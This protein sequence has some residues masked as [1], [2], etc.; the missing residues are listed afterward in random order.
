[1]T[2]LVATPADADRLRALALAWRGT[3]WVAEGALRGTGASCTGLPYGILAE[4]GHQA[5]VPPSRLG[6]RKKDILE[7]CRTWLAAHPDR[8]APVSLAQIQ[9]GDVLLF[10]CG[11]G[12]MAI[13]LGGTEVLHSWQTT[14]AH[15]ANFAEHRLASRLVGAWRPLA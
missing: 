6:I 10:D 5:P 13:A 1:M 14:G 8:Y 12:H 9:P 15:V 3:P 4:F 7:T 2:P 11:I